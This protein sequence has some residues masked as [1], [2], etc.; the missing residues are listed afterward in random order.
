MRIDNNV[1]ERKN[2]DSGQV[3]YYFNV[4]DWIVLRH[5]VYLLKTLPT[6]MCPMIS[7]SS[8]AKPVAAKAAPTVLE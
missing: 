1:A 5:Q 3:V 4:G 7:F 6:D 2:R 8:V